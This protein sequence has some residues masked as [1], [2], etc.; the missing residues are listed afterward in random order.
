MAKKA[1]TD[2]LSVVGL[3]SAILR[4]SAQQ[5]SLGKAREKRMAKLDD[6]RHPEAVAER[7]KREKKAKKEAKK[8]SKDTRSA[9]EI[10][11]DV[12]RTRSKLVDTVDAVKYDLDIPAR[13][14]DARDRVARELPDD[15]RGETKARIVAASV[16]VAGWGAIAWSAIARAR[17]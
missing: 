17:R 12:D 6:R 16:L 14:G 13:L 3:V 15:W 2:Q 4:N 8:A 11:A 9:D 1:K 5:R 10:G 7:K